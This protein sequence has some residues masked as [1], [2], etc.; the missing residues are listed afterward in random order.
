[1]AYYHLMLEITPFACH[2]YTSHVVI[3]ESPLD[4]E[5]RNAAHHSVSREDVRIV[6]YPEYKKRRVS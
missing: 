3:S 6:Q 1:M 5:A 2:S 4:W